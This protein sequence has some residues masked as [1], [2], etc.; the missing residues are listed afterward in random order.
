MANQYDPIFKT[1]K[2]SSLTEKQLQDCSSLYSEHYGCYS[3]IDN[4][5]KQGE[6]IK[7]SPSYYRSLGDN[8]NMY[9]SLCY[10]EDKL[11]GHAFFLRKTLPSGEKCSWVTQLVVHHSYRFRK[12]ATRLL[13]S[14]WGFSDYHAWGLAT[15]NAVTIKTLESVTWRKVDPVVISNHLDEIG[16]LCDEIPFADKNNIRLS[17]EKSQIFTDFYPEFQSLGKNLSEVYI[18]KLGDIEEGC[19]WLAFTFQHQ[20]MEFD[21]KHWEQMLNFS[22]S[23]LQDAYSRM[24]MNS[25]GWTRHTSHEVDFVVNNCGIEKDSCVLDVG[26]GLG[27][28]S[29]E[30]AKRGFKVSAYDFSLRLLNKAKTNANGL[31]IN[32]E[33]K[34]CRH[35]KH[36]ASFDAVICLYDVIG[37]FRTYEENVSIINSIKGSL[38]KGGRCVISVMNMEL[39]QSLAKNK[40]ENVRL[41]PE[42][43]FKLK[44]SNIMQSTGN[45]FNPDYYLLDTATNLVFRKEQFEMDEELSSEYVIADYRFT[46]DQIIQAL[47][48]NGLNVISANYVRAGAWNK[49]LNNTDLNAKEILIVA[50]KK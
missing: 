20:K 49:N 39:T 47:E 42:M 23:Q 41:H 13:Q 28:H 26:C 29:I 44:A 40:V 31:D 36:C 12:I 33:L 50:E 14:A 27:R 46:R 11:L 8:P 35:L 17:K 19:E 2:C 48:R 32:F 15:T 9:V 37:S 30:L 38:K 25:Q 4:I 22:E 21:E 45:I 18:N 10:N 6:R 43:L 7:L 1:I 34:D 24:D 5:D 3:G 16:L